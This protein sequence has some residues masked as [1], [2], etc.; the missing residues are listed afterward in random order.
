MILNQF[1]VNYQY[2]T[3]FNPYHDHSG[4]YSFA[5]WMRIP[6]DWDNQKKLSQFNDIQESQR[7][8]G[9]FEF[10]YIDTIGDIKNYSYRLSPEYEGT[11]LFFPAD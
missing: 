6:Y 4:V 8:P 2:K 10:E 9:N 7:N 11:M 1:W 3:E 5:I